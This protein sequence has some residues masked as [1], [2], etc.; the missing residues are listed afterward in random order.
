[1]DKISIRQILSESVKLYL[2]NFQSWFLAA[3]LLSVL[4]EMDLKIAYVK[5][6]LPRG[7]AFRLLDL[8]LLFGSLFLMILIFKTISLEAISYKEAAVIAGERFLK[9]LWVLLATLIITI[10]L[11][12]FIIPG[13]YFSIPFLFAGIAIVVDDY[14]PL[15]AL[16]AVNFYV[17]GNW[18]RIFLISLIYCPIFLLFDSF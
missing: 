17:R 5:S 8:I 11:L 14:S 4:L 6:S 10:G 15:N 1:M 9:Y 16:R 12:F 2:R 13:I 18:W 7:M 3:F